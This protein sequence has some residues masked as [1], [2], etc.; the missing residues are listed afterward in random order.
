MA[1]MLG[2][3]AFEAG[4]SGVFTFIDQIGIQAGLDADERGSVLGATSF[5]G[6]SGAVLAA[7]LG[8]RFGRVWP[9]T[10][11]LVLNIVAV[12]GLAVCDSGFA[13]SALNLLWGV[14]YNFLLPYLMGALAT[15]DDRGRWAVAGDSLWNGGAVPGPWIAAVLVQEAGML[16]LAGWSLVTGGICLVLV[17]GALRRFESR[18]A[19]A[20][21]PQNHSPGSPI[22]PSG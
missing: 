14:G 10:I 19:G 20:T 4:Q 1:V 16:S 2:M 18:H 5:M 17:T 8:T 9:V 3:F 6:M 12:A 11:G 7:W 21:S 15:L 22:L 13:F